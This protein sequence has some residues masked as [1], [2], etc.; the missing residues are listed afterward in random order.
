MALARDEAATGFIEHAQRAPGAEQVP[1]AAWDALRKDADQL[2]LIGLLA[3]LADA[4]P[5]VDEAVRAEVLEPIV[6]DLRDLLGADA[7]TELPAVLDAFGKA[8]GARGPEILTRGVARVIHEVWDL[9]ANRLM[10]EDVLAALDVIAWTRPPQDAREAVKRVARLS[11]HGARCV[12]G[13]MDEQLLLVHRLGQDEQIPWTEVDRPIHEFAPRIFSQRLPSMI[14]FLL[15][16]EPRMRL[17]FVIWGRLRG[18]V[19]PR[20]AVV[21]IAEKIVPEKPVKLIEALVAAAPKREALKRADA[22]WPTARTIE[23]LYLSRVLPP[24][25]PG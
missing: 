3:S 2:G 15:P 14:R 10:T 20:A 18:I 13:H 9:Q 7:P 12:L 5:T 25:G 16:D 11:R 22:A 8:K 24:P 1:A 19:L 23:A 4:E 6:R 17:A 21:A